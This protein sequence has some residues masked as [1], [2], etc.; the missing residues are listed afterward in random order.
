MCEDMSKTVAKHLTF[1]YTGNSMFPTL[2]KGDLIVLEAEAGRRPVRRGDVIVYPQPGEAHPVVHR[3]EAVTREGLVTRGDHSGTSDPGFV[4]QAQI[5]GRVR[6]I[7]RENRVLRMPRGPLCM[8]RA[9]LL[10]RLAGPA[11]AVRDFLRPVY[12]HLSRSWMPRRLLFPLFKPR[13]LCL[14]RPEGREWKLFA[15][16]REIGFLPP[17]ATAWRIRRPYLLVVDE[18]ALPA[19]RE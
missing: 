3:V 2:K 17:G 9:R 13:V 10:T 16:K 6:H 4:Q 19:E 5:Q 15:G 12:H 1:I 7:V 14:R 18:S 11:R 8:G